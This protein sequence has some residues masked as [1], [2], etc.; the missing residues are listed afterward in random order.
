MATPVWQRTADGDLGDGLPGLVQ[1]AAFVAVRPVLSRLSPL[2]AL[3]NVC[4]GPGDVKDF[5]K[6]IEQEVMCIKMH[7]KMLIKQG[8]A[9]PRHAEAHQAAVSKEGDCHPVRTQ[10]HPLSVCLCPT[11]CWPLRPLLRRLPE[12]RS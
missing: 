7:Q 1:L 9:L 6:K 4:C 10:G 5:V 12:C 8:G 2:M 11:S 3:T